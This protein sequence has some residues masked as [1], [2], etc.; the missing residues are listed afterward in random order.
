MMRQTSGG[1]KRK[2]GGRRSSSRGGRSGATDEGMPIYQR[3]RDIIADRIETGTYKVDQQLPSERDLGEQLGISRMTARHVYVTLQKDGL[4]HR[5]NRK[6]WFVSQPRLHYALMR[7]V[8]FLTNVRAEGGTPNAKVLGTGHVSAAEWLRRLLDIGVNE[9][10]TIVRRML[11]ISERPAMVATIYMPASRFPDLLE[12]P[13]EQSIS[14]LWKEH[15]GIDVARAQVTIRGGT[16]LPEDA[17]AL[18]IKQ[19]AAALRLVQVLYDADDKPIAVDVQH[20]RTDIAEFTIDV[21]F[22]L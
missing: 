16:L 15:F 18:N 2:A 6:G 4:I 12:L 3:V 20:W 17:A 8:S 5:T 1:I 11:S 22:N 14:Q 21:N 7:S 10:V 9:R 19:N 13:L